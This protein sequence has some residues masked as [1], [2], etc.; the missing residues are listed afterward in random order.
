MI[1][2][3]F[4]LNAKSPSFKELEEASFHDLSSVKTTKC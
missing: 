4:M 3:E 2:Y 1:Q